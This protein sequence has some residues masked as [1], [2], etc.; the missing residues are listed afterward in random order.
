M[1]QATTNETDRRGQKRQLSPLNYNQLYSL[2][3]NDIDQTDENEPKQVYRGKSPNK[4]KTKT[5]PRIKLTKDDNKTLYQGIESGEFVVIPYIDDVRDTTN[6]Q[7]VSIIVRKQNKLESGRMFDDK[8][9]TEYDKTKH[10]NLK[11]SIGDVPYVFIC[12]ACYYDEDNDKPTIWKF[13]SSN[14]NFKNHMLKCHGLILAFRQWTMAER[15]Q[16]LQPSVEYCA[17]DR[18][19]FHGLNGDG[20]KSLLKAVFNLGCSVGQQVESIGMKNHFHVFKFIYKITKHICTDGLL[21]GRTT[22]STT[23]RDNG[24]LI[25][26]ER[27]EYYTNYYSDYGNY[28]Y[29]MST[30][31]DM[32]KSRTFDDYI[33]LII[34]DPT[35][36]IYIVLNWEDLRQFTNICGLALKD[37]ES[38][39][40]FF[41]FELY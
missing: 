38:S 15:L 30:E 36:G 18:K 13:N 16:I 1:A 35:L 25:E 31:T 17:W 37:S 26:I 24:V 14:G 27:R 28:P 9:Q 12:T 33:N 41:F 34:R 39:V 7:Y 20:L 5:K 32:W 23:S 22:I 3:D 4:K 21:F 6:Y 29:V 2:S 8:K 40:L 10:I 19:S 11:L